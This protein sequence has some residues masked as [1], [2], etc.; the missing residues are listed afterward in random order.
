MEEFSWIMKE[1]NK[2]VPTRFTE[3]GLFVLSSFL[4]SLNQ[5]ITHAYCTYPL[6]TL[7]MNNLSVEISFFFN[8]ELCMWRKNK[9][10]KIQTDSTKCPQKWEEKK[11]SCF[12]LFTSFFSFSSRISISSL[13]PLPACCLFIVNK[14][15]SACFQQN[16][17]L[18]FFINQFCII[19]LC[20]C[21]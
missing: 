20:P 10:Q 2:Y 4:S 5:N 1:F 3:L 6:F 7:I 16:S 17:L 14:I 12:F 13:S 21:P 11:P 15:S 18:S 8:S 9:Q 19:S